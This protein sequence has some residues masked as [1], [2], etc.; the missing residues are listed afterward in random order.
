M[1]YGGK[2]IACCTRPLDAIVARGQTAERTLS[3]VCCLLYAAC[4]ALHIRA[5]RHSTREGSGTA[6]R[7]GLKSAMPSVVGT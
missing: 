2:G 4:C 3:V 1:V 7:C 5:V 6:F